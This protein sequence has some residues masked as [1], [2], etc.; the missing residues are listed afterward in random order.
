MMER[1][2]FVKNEP[3]KK[4]IK[5]ADQQMDTNYKQ[6][7]ISE[8]M[9]PSVFDK[10]S[11]IPRHFQSL[12]LLPLY[13]LPDRDNE[14]SSPCKLSVVLQSCNSEGLPPPSR[15]GPDRTTQA[16]LTPP[17]PNYLLC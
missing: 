1:G 7:H 12:D 15:L 16:H 8:P 11:S 17:N 3:V 10:I 4:R 2:I 14:D 6:A 5:F 13:H 9:G